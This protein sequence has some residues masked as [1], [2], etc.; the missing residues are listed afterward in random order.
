MRITIVSNQS[1]QLSSC[2]VVPQDRTENSVDVAK[3]PT[4][5]IFLLWAVMK[6]DVMVAQEGSPPTQDP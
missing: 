3:Y 4:S 5:E 2:D 1:M 6:R